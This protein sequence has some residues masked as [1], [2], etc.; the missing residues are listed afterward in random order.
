M[1]EVAYI[2]C[3]IDTD[4]TIGIR[5]HLIRKKYLTFEPYIQFGNNFKPVLEKIKKQ[6]KIETKIQKV[7]KKRKDGT[8]YKRPSYHLRVYKLKQIERIIVLV[9]P[10]LEIKRRQ[11]VLMLEYVRSRLSRPYSRYTNRERELFK[12]ISGLNV[13]GEELYKYERG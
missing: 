13:K 12:K 8:R 1:L 3:F 5:N 4:G 9:L 10:Y 11:G 7:F 6:L 2:A